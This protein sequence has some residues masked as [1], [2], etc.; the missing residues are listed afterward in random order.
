M[1]VEG[2]KMYGGMLS[3]E[4]VSK[5]SVPKRAATRKEDTR[6]RREWRREGRERR[7]VTEMRVSI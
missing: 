4:V 2:K 7:T 1:A 5:A 3:S 6:E